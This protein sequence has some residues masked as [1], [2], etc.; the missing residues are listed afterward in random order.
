METHKSGELVTL[1]QTLHDCFV[2][3]IVKDK[4]HAQSGKPYAFI[5]PFKGSEYEINIVGFSLDD[6]RCIFSFGS[7]DD[8]IK[9][10]ADSTPK[11]YEVVEWLKEHEGKKITVKGDYF[12]DKKEMAVINF[13]S[14]ED[15]TK[16]LLEE[17]LE[18]PYKV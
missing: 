17:P 11:F 16:P 18:K 10:I 12:S 5:I 15:I 13:Y 14:E 3:G 2:T 1:E 7:F 8:N 4:P 9:K 6:L